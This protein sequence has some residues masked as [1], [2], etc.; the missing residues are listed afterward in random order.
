M[1]ETVPELLPQI[2]KS[3][4]NIK[5]KGPFNSTKWLSNADLDNVLK[6]YQKQYPKFKFYPSCL[7]NESF[8]SIDLYQDIISDD[9]DSVACVVNT[10]EVCSGSGSC[11][12]HWVCIYMEKTSSAITLEFFNSAGSPPP[13]KVLR[14]FK[15]AVDNM[16]GDTRTIVEKLTQCP[17]QQNDTECGVYCLYFIRSRLEGIAFERFT[18]S[19]M[20]S[21]EAMIMFRRY[22]FD[23][24]LNQQ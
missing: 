17:H 2:N 3:L 15:T 22:I 4:E 12:E 21:D 14:M 5:P 11:G 18:N 19:T 24:P 16:R 23:I 6:S 1:K 10:T 9:V 7:M 13:P 20:I 8:T